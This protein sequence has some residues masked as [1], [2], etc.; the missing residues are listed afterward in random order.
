[1][2]SLSVLQLEIN[3]GED[4]DR[5][6]Q[7]VEALLDRAGDCDLAVLPELWNIGYFSFDQY[8]KESE[9]LAGP[10]LG[11][12]AAKARER[13]MHVFAGS[14]VERDGK[15]L[16]NTSVLFSPQG[17]IMATYRKLHLFGYGSREREIV[18]SGSRVVVAE[19][20]FGPVGIST[21][22]DLRFPELYRR[23]VD[24]GAILF[25][26][27]SAWPYPRLEHWH[28]FTRTRAVENLAFLVA[29][30]CCGVNRGI[31]FVGHSVV[32]D[33][34][35]IPVASAGDE[36]T[37]LKTEIDVSAPARVRQAFPALVDRRD[38]SALSSV[39]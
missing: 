4:K 20:P 17:E 28:L 1:M 3:D 34:W 32:V 22:Y 29:S 9:P 27:A 39:D 38:L 8:Q 37:V 13:R 19:T 6:L 25:L 12:I 23:M 35:G 21:C 31:R 18:T 11:R 36:E 16:Y 26:V 33:P 15:N 7:R 24:K 10:T 5:R 2:L 30:N 14:M